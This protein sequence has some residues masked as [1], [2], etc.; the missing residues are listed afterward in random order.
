M[1]LIF[2]LNLFLCFYFVFSDN[3]QLKTFTIDLDD[4][5]SQRFIKPTIEFK[6]ELIGFIDSQRKLINP[7]AILLIEQI[8]ARLDQ[9]LPYPYNEEI[10][11]ISEITGIRL[12]DVVLS[13]L[14]Y[15]ITTFCTSIVA[16]NSHGIIMH[17]RN[18]DYNFK[19][20]LKNLIYEAKFVK[21]GT[22]LYTSLQP[23]GYIGILTAHKYKSFTF[24][25][26]ERGI[27]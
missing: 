9:L 3:F 5:P 24:S 6:T 18:L 7:K 14:I 17:G 10:K 21:N 25:I 19:D 12:G 22:L 11:G 15:D 26:N 23:A 16:Q 2:W 4:K 20:Y 1:S 8:A 13:N 27:S